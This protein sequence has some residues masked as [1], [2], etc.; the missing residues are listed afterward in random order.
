MQ[1]I[2]KNNYSDVIGSFRRGWKRD[3]PTALAKQLISS[4]VAEAAVATPPAPA[5]KPGDSTQPA[6]QKTPKPKRTRRPRIAQLA[7]VTTAPET[8]TAT[9]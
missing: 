9:A 1:V 3:L 8:S 5:G 2:F 4:G 6:A 7:T